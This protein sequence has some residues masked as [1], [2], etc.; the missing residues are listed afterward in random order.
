MS[1]T[2]ETSAPYAPTS[3][4]MEIVRRFRDKGNPRPINSESLTRIGV[5]DSLNAR[6][7]QA[8]RTLDLVDEKGD[9]TQTFEGIRLASTE[10]YPKV[11]QDW[12]MAAYADVFSIVDPGTDDETRVRDAFRHYTPSGQHGR[13]V[14]L[15]L[16]LCEE[17]GI[18]QKSPKKD[19][20]A[21]PRKKSTVTRTSSVRRE[22]NAA[23]LAKPQ[24][25]SGLPVALSGL[26]GSLPDPFKGWTQ[27]ERD[28]FI[29]TFGVVLDYSYPIRTAKEMEDNNK[30]ENENDG[31]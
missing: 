14:S 5:P 20:S 28:K 7:L 12:L 17:A 6:T 4:I 9:P 15:F 13:M 16:G 24:I 25:D 2:A 8:L 31:I 27:A 22:R 26:L 18:R 21:N 23:P 10:G 1:V 30:A 11:L 3:Q 29:T 19:T